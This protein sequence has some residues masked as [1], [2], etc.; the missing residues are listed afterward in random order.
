VYQDT[1]TVIL[2][3]NGTLMGDFSTPLLITGG[4][5]TLNGQ[6]TAQQS[7][8]IGGTARL[9]LN[10][11]SAN[12]YGSL[13]TSGSGT[14][15]MTSVNDYLNIFLTATF[16]GG[17]ETGLL[18]AGAINLGG[19]VIQAGSPTAFAPSGTHKMIL[20]SDGLQT[21]TFANPAT[22]FFQDLD[23]IGAT[24]MELVSDVTVKGTLAGPGGGV[25]FSS[26]TGN[27]LTVSG[28]NFPSSTDFANVRLKYVDGVAGSTTFNNATFGGLSAGATAFEFNRTSG[29]PYNFISLSFSGVLN[30]SGRYIVNTGTSLLT[31]ISPNPGS[32]AAASICGCAVWFTPGTG[33]ITWP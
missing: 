22:S 21:V 31:L 1:G 7:V 15:Q 4:T 24:E 14:L 28:L 26:A 23:V 2:T 32:T 27:L 12:I 9:V 29:G 16:A 18:T 30:T 33:G 19:D 20:N 13:T 3:G 17:S 10:G 6:F 11:T 5:H 8:T 25:Y